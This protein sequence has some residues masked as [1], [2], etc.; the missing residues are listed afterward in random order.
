MLVKA[1]IG[2]NYGDEGKGL[3][4]NFLVEQAIENKRKVAGVLNNGGAQRGHTVVKDNIRH[5]F[6][7]FG[8][9]TLNNAPTFITDQFV[10][11]PIVFVEEY[12]ELLE[13]GIEPKV[14]IDKNALITLPYDMMINQMACQYMKK[15]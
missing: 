13:L 14:Y 6:H 10:L 4:T 11:N 1:V 8:S 15:N 2:A 3:V 7:H 9:G 12:K 5:V